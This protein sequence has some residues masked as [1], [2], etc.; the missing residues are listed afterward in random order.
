MRGGRI[1]MKKILNFLV[2][3]IFILLNNLSFAEIPKAEWIAR[4][5]GIGYGDGDDI[6]NAIAVDTSGN[7]YVT[8]SSDGLGTNEDYVTVKY[9]YNGNKL[10]VARYNG[11]G[12]G[13][14]SAFAIAIDETGNVYVTG[15]S[16]SSTTYTDWATIKY[17]SNGNEL[18]VARYNGPGGCYDRGNAIAID[19]S[20]NVY[21]TGLSDCYSDITTI[22]YDT[23]GN[24]LWVARYSGWGNQDDMGNAIAID[25][26]GNVYVTGESFNDTM[27]CTTIKYD[28]S[29]NQLWVATQSG[30]GNAVVVDENGN[31]FV[32]GA[33][34]GAG[35]VVKYDNG[36][37]K[38][39]ERRNNNLGIDMD[40]DRS[41]NIYTAGFIWGDAITHKD[42]IT[43]KYDT[44]GN[45][46]WVARYDSPEHGDDYARAIVIDDVGNVYVTGTSGESGPNTEKYNYITIKYDTSG[47]EMWVS[48]YD[49]TGNSWDVA[50]AVAVDFNG[51]VYVTGFSL[52]NGA[53]QDY[54][55]IKYDANGNEIWTA[56]YD[57]PAN[58]W[59]E[60]HAM[61]VDSSGNVYVTGSSYGGSNEDFNYA[62]VKYDTNGNQ[63]WVALYDGPANGFDSPNAIA[64]D[65][66][67][68]LYVTGVVK[69]I[70]NGYDYGTVKYDAN[71]NQ[72]WVATYNG[73]LNGNDSAGAI[74]VDANGYVYVTGSIANHGTEDDIMSDFATVK[75]DTNGNQLWVTTYNGTG[76][77]DDAARYIALDQNRN[78]YVTGESDGHDGCGC[79]DYVTIKYDTNGNKLWVARYNGP[80]DDHDSPRGMAIVN[81][82]NVYVT[83]CT[84]GGPSSYP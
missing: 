49:G 60:V 41:G 38:L 74:S 22:K 48:K 80:G 37:N 70:D 57:G 81:L 84:W 66:S 53:T 62:T 65:G 67:G 78:V 45:E 36:G 10:W 35:L 73:L 69:T 58:D 27:N 61:A 14:D 50:K 76:N 19:Q 77:G 31:V 75:Y 56:R 12:N 8:G 42:C 32:A 54:V 4:Y 29:G 72:I 59:D 34:G 11:P 20:G 79:A 55:T 18:W 82:G 24:Q 30:R 44:N 46:L 9:D 63:L 33:A 7:V 5:N 21:V 26:T 13:Y 83:G 52:D 3:V 1:T 25:E 39:W 47:N 15:E 16:S 64:V 6:S 23:N 2:F 17:D 43:V 28:S 51:N 71:G 68:N 40:I